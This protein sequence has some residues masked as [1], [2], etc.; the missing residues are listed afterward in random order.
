MI[1]SKQSF[2]VS[3]FFKHPVKRCYPDG[4]AWVNSLSCVCVWSTTPY[5][6]LPRSSVD[7]DITI[8]QTQDRHKCL[9][10]TVVPSDKYSTCQSIYA[11]VTNDKQQWQ[12]LVN[13]EVNFVPLC[14]LKAYGGVKVYIRSFFILAWEGGESSDSSSGHLSPWKQ[15]PWL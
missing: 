1:V 14:A 10:A 2:F 3:W 5:R 9:M 12:L 7:P 15:T 8:F 13:G 6:Q 11:P 4:K